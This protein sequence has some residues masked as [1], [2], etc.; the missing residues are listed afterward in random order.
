MTGE[1]ERI[2]DIEDPFE[3]LRLATERLATAQRDVTE[4]SRLRRRV[5]QDLHGQG[6]SRA[7]EREGFRL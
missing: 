1:V 6:M 2:A 3:L 4:L 5:I 7:E